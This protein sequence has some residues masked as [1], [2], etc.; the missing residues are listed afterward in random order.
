WLAR[1]E[2]EVLA[3]L[4]AP[5]WYGLLG[6]LSECPVIPDAVTAV[7][8]R[9]AGRVDPSAFAFIATNAHIQAGRPL[10]AP[11]P[12]PL[13]RRRGPAPAA[14]CACGRARPRAPRGAGAP[15]IPESVGASHR[16]PSASERR[17]TW[18]SSTRRA[19]RASFAASRSTP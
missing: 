12:R 5:A 1:D 6:L 9:R 10:H 15:A 4:D 16:P 3:A 8:E 18:P 13:S 11:R 2:L 19:T 17:T 7:V 14:V